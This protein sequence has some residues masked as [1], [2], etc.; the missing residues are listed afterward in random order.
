MLPEIRPLSVRSGEVSRNPDSVHLRRLLC[1]DGRQ[2]GDE[3]CARA[4]DEPASIHHPII[5]FGLANAA[6]CSTAKFEV[7]AATAGV[8]GAVDHG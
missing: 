5:L 6:V 3:E 2:P 1:R 8:E 4:C 7:S